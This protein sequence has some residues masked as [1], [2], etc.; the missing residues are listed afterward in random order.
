MKLPSLRNPPTPPFAK[1]GS[2]GG[3]DPAKSPR[4]L[5]IETSSPRLSLAVGTDT[6]VLK[7]F[8]GPLQWRHADNL[9]QGMRRLLAAVRWPVQSLTGVVVSVGPGSFTGIRIGLAAARA[10]GQ[11]LKVP[12]VGISSLQTIAY[13]VLR[14][15]PARVAC[16]CI[17]ALRGEVFTGLYVMDSGGWL[18][19]VWR[20]CRL[21]RMDWAARLKSQSTWDIWLA[22][23]AICEREKFPVSAIRQNFHRAEESLWYPRA[24]H[25][26]ALGRRK[27]RKAGPD[28]YQ[29]VLPLYLRPPA[30][31]ARASTVT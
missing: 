24:S 19:T 26:L 28:S 31:V 15:N 3:F 9:F 16:P 17:D 12:V 29:H 8:Q 5:A 7:E 20:D 18:K 2:K 30:A 14:R 10:L 21:S 27:L 13:G 4:Y 11:S 25:L 22:G 23:D 6:E 1:G